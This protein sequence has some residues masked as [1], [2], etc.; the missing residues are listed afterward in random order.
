MNT[1][2]NFI[3]KK[4][5]SLI[6]RLKY[7]TGEYRWVLDK[8]IPRFLED[9]TFLGYIG[10]LVDI[11]D[12]IMAEEKIRFQAGLIENASDVIIS[13]DE[14]FNVITW[15]KRAEEIYETP[16]AAALTKNMRDLVAHQL[17]TDT[18]E[19]FYVALERQGSWQGEVIHQKKNGEKVYLLCMV[20]A[21]KDSNNKI[22]GYISVNRDIT[23]K[24]I[25]EEKIKSNELKFKAILQN[26]IDV[27]FVLNKQTVIKYVTPSVITVLG[28][29]EQELN[30]T[31]RF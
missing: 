25:A 12:Y 4:P 30:G 19:S 2:K 14:H 3:E 20:S 1:K 9:G 5:V 8:S 6:Y 13:T 11:H 16:V 24:I 31:E 18:P 26:L 27:V 23:E 28:Y 17:L 29:N 10:S 21:F 7:R 22:T 15:N